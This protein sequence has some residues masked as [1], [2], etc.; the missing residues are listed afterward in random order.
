MESLKIRILG[1]ILKTFTLFLEEFFEKV[2]SENKNRQPKHENIPIDY[3]R[4]K[5][6]NK[7]TFC[8]SQG[9]I[10]LC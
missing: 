5:K 8:N 10:L 4:V 2:D 9:S 6:K 3:A 7:N 1:L